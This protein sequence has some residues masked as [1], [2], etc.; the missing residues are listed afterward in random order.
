MAISSIDVHN[1]VP[2]H[3]HTA[4]LQHIRL[5]SH[6]PPVSFLGS[7]RR[8]TFNEVPAVIRLP[9]QDIGTNENV[10]EYEGGFKDG[11]YSSVCHK[12]LRAV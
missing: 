7:G 11:R 5:Q 9:F 8:F 4:P 3:V 10:I 2:V 12:N 1:R 6:V